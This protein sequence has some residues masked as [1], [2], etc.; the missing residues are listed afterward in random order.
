MIFDYF[1]N[2]TL[3]NTERGRI[4]SA[5]NRAVRRRRLSLVARLSRAASSWAQA[6]RS[7]MDPACPPESQRATRPACTTTVRGTCWSR[8]PSAPA[9][10][11]LGHQGFGGGHRGVHRDRGSAQH[12]ARPG[13]ADAAR[14][15]GAGLTLNNHPDDPFGGDAV[16]ISR[17]PHGRRRPA[18]LAHRDGQPARRPRPA[19]RDSTTGTGKSPRSARAASR[20]RPAAAATAGCARISCSSSWISAPTTRSADVQPAGRDRRDHHEPG[21]PGRVQ[22]DHGRRLGLRRAVRDGR[23]RAHDGGGRRVSGRGSFGHAGRPVRA[24]PHLRHG[25]PC[26]RRPSATSG[27]RSSSSRCRC[28]RPS[29]CRSPAATTTT[30]TSADTTNPKVALRWAPIDSLAFRASWG[31]G[32]RAPS[33]AQIGLG[34][35]QES[36]FFTGYVRLR[37][38]PGLLRA[39]PH[40]LPTSIVFRAIR[41]CSLRSPRTSMSAWSGSRPARLELL[42]RLLGHRAGQQDRRGAARLHLRAGV[43][44]PGEHDLRA[45]HAAP[46]RH[47]RAAAVHPQH[48][49]STSVSRRQR[50]STSRRTRASTSATAALTLGLDYSHLLKFDKVVLGADGLTFETQEFAGEYEYPEDRAALTGDYRFGDWGVDARVNY[51]GSFKDFRTLSPPGRGSRVAHGRVRSRR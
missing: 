5:N 50:A 23:G 26:R 2:Q 12:V 37:G 18:P 38:Q 48:A 30:A 33:L 10:M 51:I 25:S 35:S 20:R 47:A 17:Y 4:G 40:R 28:S 3:F 8:S 31:E 36:E 42:A 44:Q 21:A 43:Q 1:K 45:R 49:S 27:R 14:R 6:R 9:C 7:R 41:T 11:L 46:G 16:G 13:R 24:R 34:P 32:F 22:P 15:D 39:D 29:S 19:R